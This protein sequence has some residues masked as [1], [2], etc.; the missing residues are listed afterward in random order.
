VALRGGSARA[1]VRQ[2]RVLAPSEYRPGCPLCHPCVSAWQVRARRG[3]H[4]GGGGGGEG[5]HRRGDDARGAD[6]RHRAGGAGQGGDPRAGPGA[7]RRQR[8]PARTSLHPCTSCTGRCARQVF[9]APPPQPNYAAAPQY[10]QQAQQQQQQQGTPRGGG[11]TPRGGG[12]TP[13][14]GSLPKGWKE[15]AHPSGTYYYNKSTRETTRIRP[16]EAT[17]PKARGRSS[18]RPRSRAPP[19]VSRAPLARRRCPRRACSTGAEIAASA[20]EAGH[21]R[22]VAVGGAVGSPDALCDDNRGLVCTPLRH[23]DELTLCSGYATRLRVAQGA[24]GRA[25]RI[26]GG[27]P[28]R[29]TAACDVMIIRSTSTVVRACTRARDTRLSQTARVHRST[30]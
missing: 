16:T 4:R 30:K 28:L 18:G 19:Y 27:W 5:A 2:A 3:G 25:R 14:D 12:S 21:A 22:C 10:A 24:R 17:G 20:Y 13:R 1:R 29:L 9:G 11:S 6:A 7:P 8:R 23:D 15:V 26:G